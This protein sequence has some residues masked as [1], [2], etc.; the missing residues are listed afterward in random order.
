MSEPVL[1]E[2]ADESAVGEV[3]RIAA[4]FGR[5]MNFAGDVIGRV[6]VVASELASNLVK[7]AGR[8]FVVMN[9]DE[10]RS[11]LEIL[12]L[13]HGPGIGDV[14]EALR[15]GYSTSGT[16]GT[17][18]GAISRQADFFNIYTR[19]QHGTVVLARFGKSRG[20]GE[21]AAVSIPVHGELMNGDGWAAANGAGT[22]TIMVVDGL[23]HGAL[24]HEASAAARA[25]FQTSNGSPTNRLQTIHDGLKHTRGAAV[26]IAELD[27]EAGTM[28]FAGIGNI[29]AITVDP[30]ARRSAV[31]MHG[32][33]GHEMR[34]VREFQY[35]WS[36]QSALIMHSDGLTTRWNLDDYPALMSRDPAVI[37]GVLGN[38][39]RR[40]N[41][42]ATVVVARTP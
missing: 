15:D 9:R 2:V 1:I 10:D 12:S 8:G 5:Q 16:V 20:M 38:D 3:R 23:G 28:R 22:R 18:L 36:R 19:R 27:P 30:A 25:A 32:I 14:A 31:S 41:D 40:Q 6:S 35:P 33:A 42:D 34:Q 39:H 26:A 21:V 7:H 17:G 37:A 4:E 11:E 13:D 29:S 24:A